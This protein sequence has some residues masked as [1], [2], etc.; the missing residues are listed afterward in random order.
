M[1][2]VVFTESQTWYKNLVRVLFFLNF[3]LISPTPHPHTHISRI[4]IA[5]MVTVYL[6]FNSSYFL[7]ADIIT[8]KS[9]INRNCIVKHWLYQVVSATNLELGQQLIL[10]VFSGSCLV[11]NTTLAKLGLSFFCRLLLDL[12]LPRSVQAHASLFSA[13]LRLQLILFKKIIKVYLK[14]YSFEE[15]V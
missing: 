8:S 6:K 12:I 1:P 11:R 7:T 2:R 9:Q 3:W 13:E 5:I 15:K 4:I 10:K 14:L